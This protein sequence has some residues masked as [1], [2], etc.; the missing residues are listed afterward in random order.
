MSG[1]EAGAGDVEFQEGVCYLF[2]GMDQRPGSETCAFFQNERDSRHMRNTFPTRQALGPSPPWF[3]DLKRAFIT[4]AP[5]PL[6]R[7]E[8]R[9]A[10]GKLT[11]RVGRVVRLP[12]IGP[13]V[14]REGAGRWRRWCDGWGAGEMV[15]R[16]AGEGSEGHHLLLGAGGRWT[17]RWFCRTWGRGAQ[18]LIMDSYHGS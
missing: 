6:S 11:G 14:E 2:Q 9:F 3:D 7:R 8:G 4:F 1:E 18:H 16:S 17:V 12:V 10:S 13:P 15:G 5:R